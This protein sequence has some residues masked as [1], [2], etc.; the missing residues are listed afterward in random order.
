V[1]H[2]RRDFSLLLNKFFGFIFLKNFI[3][4]F[5]ICPFTGE[6]WFILK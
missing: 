3:R 1:E 2:R 4:G 6:V 5:I